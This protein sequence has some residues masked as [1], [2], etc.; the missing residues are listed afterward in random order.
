MIRSKQ[1]ELATDSKLFRRKSSKDQ[2]VGSE[3]T[4]QPFRERNWK[5]I[6]GLDQIEDESKRRIGKAAN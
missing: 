1:F 6:E 4:P 3:Y 2:S 5:N